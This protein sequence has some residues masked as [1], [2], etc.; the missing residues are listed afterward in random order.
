MMIPSWRWFGPKDPVRLHEIRQCGAQW[1]VSA[2]HQVPVGEAWPPEDIRKR[3][4]LIEEAGLAWKVVESVPVHEDIKV[5]GGD[6][7][8]YIANFKQTIRSLGQAGIEVLC[9]NFMPALDWSRTQ[10]EEV[11]PDGSLQ[12]SFNYLHFAAI[13]LFIL[14]RPGA[15]D[16]Y[17]ED[18][19]EKAKSYFAGLDRAEKQRLEDTFLLGF[20]GSGEAFSLAQVRQRVARYADTGKEELRSKLAAFLGEVL[21]VAEE[22]GIRLALHP[23]DPPFPLMGLPRI[24][25]S[26]EDARAILSM[27]HSPSNGLTLCS[28][29]LGAGHEND[30]AQVARECA[31]RI[32]FAHL[33]NVCRDASGNFEEKHLLEGDIDIPAIVSALLEEKRPIPYRPDHGARILGDRERDTYPGY[34]LYGRMKSLA[35]LKGLVAGLGHQSVKPG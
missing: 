22:A 35:E 32:H 25:S 3:K 7:P 15:A 30:S 2:L 14:E 28:G 1:I 19:A 24:Y 27:N 4:T 26:L 13:D 33:R 34:P 5:G 23:D 8:R 18:L 21:P 11:A 6:F 16:D 9:Y 20:P 17:P 29:S 31:P 12:S 10:L